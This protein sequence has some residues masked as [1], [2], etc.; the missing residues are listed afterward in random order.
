MLSALIQPAEKIQAVRLSHD[1]TLINMY[2]HYLD[3]RV[4]CFGAD[5]RVFKPVLKII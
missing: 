1:C 3:N 2:F 5:L 4:G